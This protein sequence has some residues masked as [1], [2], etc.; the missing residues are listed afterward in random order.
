HVRV[1][2]VGDPQQ[3][4]NDAAAAF[5]Y[6]QSSGAMLENFEES[7]TEID[8]ECEL[9]V[10]ALLGSGLKGEVRPRYRAAIQM[11]NR[12]D[13]PVLAVDIP[14]GLCADTGNELGHAVRASKTVTFIG[15]KRGLLTGQGPDLAGELVFSSL[16]VPDRIYTKVRAETVKL[17]WE[18]NV[19]S[20]PRRS[21]SA[22]KRHF[23]HVL[24]VGG[25]A[26]MGGAVSMAAE[27]ALRTGAGL[28]SVATHPVHA[29]SLIVRRPEL[30]VRG[31]K[32]PDELDPLLE[33]ASVVVLG[34][35]LGRSQWSVGLFERIIGESLPLVIDAD[36]LNMLA[37]SVSHRDNWILTPH[38]GEASRLLTGASENGSN[39]FTAIQRLQETYGGVVLL[40]GAGTLIYGGDAQAAGST[41]RLCPYGNPGM[42][43]AGMGD[44]LSG[45]IGGL[46]AQ[47]LNLLDSAILGAVVHARAADD[48]AAREGERGMVATDLI[49]VVRRLLNER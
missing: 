26:G 44:V 40:K 24:I 1:I 4:G 22:H 20:L 36:G 33:R 39:R 32:S 7:G 9:M 37:Q 15:L 27:A 13:L 25:D 17:A 11:I 46:V 42:S 30:M 14:S 10:D 23:G 3:L 19:A 29:G 34:P 35:G 43:S 47:G 12:A 28:V 41:T 16:D 48:L 6:C 5:E 21:R 49:P 18:R 2:M 45:I 31:V 8:P 38:P